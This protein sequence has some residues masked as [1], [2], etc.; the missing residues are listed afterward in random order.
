MKLQGLSIRLISVD[1]ERALLISTPQS[2]EI[3]GLDAS[4]YTVEQVFFPSKDKTM[5]MND[6]MQ[7]CNLVK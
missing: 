4:Q 5:V 3:K 7:I 6:I 1:I 2:T